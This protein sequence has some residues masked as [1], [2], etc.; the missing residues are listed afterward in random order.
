MTD[1]RPADVRPADVRPVNLGALG[2]PPPRPA[3]VPAAPPERT[4]SR[5]AEA[6][7]EVRSERATPKAAERPVSV[8]S[9]RAASAATD[10][11]ITKPVA[12]PPAPPATREKREAAVREITVRDVK[13]V[14]DW[15]LAPARPRGSFLGKLAGFLA[16]AAIVA[17]GYFG[18]LKFAPPS[19]VVSESN[20]PP[21]AEA[22]A[23]TRTDQADFG[24][25]DPFDEPFDGPIDD[26]A[27]EPQIRPEKKTPRLAHHNPDAI[28]I[29]AVGETTGKPGRMSVSSAAA[30]EGDDEEPL[31]DLPLDLDEPAVAT[32]RESVN[33]SEPPLLRAPGTQRDAVALTSTSGTREANGERA[34][35]EIEDDARSGF[36]LAEEP[37]APARNSRRKPATTEPTDI[38]ELEGSKAESDPL[39]GFEPEETNRRQASSR[40]VVMRSGPAAPAA[41][42]AENDGWTVDDSPPSANT[43]F[44]RSTENS[45]SSAQRITPRHPA[46]GT[47]SPQPR[48]VGELR[49]ARNPQPHSDSYTVAPSDNF[50]VISRKR[51][52]SGRYFAALAKHNQERI[53]DP[54]RL[55]AGMHVSTPPVSV[56]EELYPELIDK[57]G[58]VSSATVP[59]MRE[60]ATGRPTFEKPTTARKA[61]MG[62]SAP[63]TAPAGYFYSKSGAPMYRIGADD[64][65][66]SIAQRHLG[67][68]SRWTEIYEQNPEV[69]KNPENLSPGTVIRLPPDAAQIGL[70]PEVE[71]RR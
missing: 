17:G 37:V 4:T 25:G 61:I 23:G 68:A 43:A 36:D 46:A 51:Y 55:R 62:E 34:A 38:P 48:S 3:V 60:P 52:G 5:V 65:L 69:L 44:G 64:T 24:T 18:Y 35:P 58:A 67:K 57:S 56:L 26:T 1:L 6:V 2:N 7:A 53:P 45:S 29:Q 15:G 31:L 59:A 66:S 49:P 33:E 71:R 39:D 20:D 63:A 8:I 50:W 13:D 12:I 19:T 16:L 41:T 28:P 42:A 54:Q 70:A 21:A 9:E 22:I 27:L 32:E 40:T 47:H 11:P 14:K 30:D 10:R